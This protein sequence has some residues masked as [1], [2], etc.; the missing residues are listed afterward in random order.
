MGFKTYTENSI[1]IKEAVNLISKLIEI[2]LHYDSMFDEIKL[3]FFFDNLEHG[4][5]LK[6]KQG[7]IRLF[8][9]LKSADKTIKELIGNREILIRLISF[10]TNI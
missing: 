1:T 9:T 8:K 5:F 3:E 7:H 4:V 10:N 2:H 6:T